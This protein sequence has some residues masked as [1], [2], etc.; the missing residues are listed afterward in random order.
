MFKSE[1][2][3]WVTYDVYVVTLDRRIWCIV[4]QIFSLSTGMNTEGI[5]R[6]SGNKHDTAM[7]LTKFDT[8]MSLDCIYISIK[9]KHIFFISKQVWSKDSAIPCR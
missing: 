1:N 3:F 9:T 5:Y 6:V 2:F 4:L 7:L 8:G